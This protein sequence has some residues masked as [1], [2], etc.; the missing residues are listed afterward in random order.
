MRKKLLIFGVIVTTIFSL[1]ACSK[2][3]GEQLQKLD[4]PFAFSEV[5][6]GN[7]K[8]DILEICG[9]SPTQETELF[10]GY[11]DLDNIYNCTSQWIA[12]MLNDSDEVSGI[13]GTWKTETEDG[14]KLIYDNLKEI[15]QEEYGDDFD[16]THGD[17][18]DERTVW[19]SS[20]CR[21]AISLQLNDKLN[22]NCVTAEYTD[23]Q[24]MVQ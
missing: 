9:E 16:A 5:K 14:A 13:S 12:Y 3:D 20:N 10:V 15:C 2:K 4:S 17:E 19:E 23:Y 24:K 22:G 7:S 18:V 11:D 1:T 21:V 8:A 6:I